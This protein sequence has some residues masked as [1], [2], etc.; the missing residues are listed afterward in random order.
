[1]IV[2]I[3]FRLKLSLCEDTKHRFYNLLIDCRCSRNS[4]RWRKQTLFYH[5]DV[6]DKSGRSKVFIKK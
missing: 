1:M 5:S 6:Q 2:K 4:V 3:L